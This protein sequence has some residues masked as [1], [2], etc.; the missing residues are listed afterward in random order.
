MLG[1]PA[2]P[3]LLFD[4]TA[5]YHHA[6]IP[7]GAAVIR[8]LLAAKGIRVVQ[9]ADARRFTDKG[10]AR[11]S[12]VVFLSTTGNVLNPSQQGALRRFVQ[13]GGG[14]A[15]IHAASDTEH[16][17]PWYRTL[18]G[19]WFAH[20]APGL[21]RATLIVEDRHNP[22]TRSLPARWVRTDEW[23]AFDHDP[24]G[25]VHVLI[26][27]DEHG[28]TGATMGGDHPV[29]WCHLVGK[30]RSWYTAGGH[31]A[32]AFDEPAFRRHLV[33][34]ILWAAGRVSADCST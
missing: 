25:H 29:A 15:G 20:H 26:R 28:F 4:R 13:R 24:R 34:G 17:W 31:P 10:L 33:G 6:S 30:G 27:L 18:V 14:Y 9:T 5:A 12:A 2:Q 7:H 32:S 23:Y 22:S 16:S 11:Y 19:A 21:Q 1:A 3:V 8:R